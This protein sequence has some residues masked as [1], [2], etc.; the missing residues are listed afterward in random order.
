MKNVARSFFNLFGAS[1]RKN[2]AKFGPLAGLRFYPHF[3]TMAFD[4]GFYDSQPQSGAFGGIAAAYFDLIK[5]IKNFVV[6][7]FGNARPRILY[8]NHDNVS[9]VHSVQSNPSLRGE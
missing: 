3:S 5:L 2:E 4:N 8:G 1:A 9:F 6:L 7:F